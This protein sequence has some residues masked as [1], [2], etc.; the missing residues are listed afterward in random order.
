ME[1][2]AVCAND[3]I[4]D[5]PALAAVRKRIADRFGLVPS[6]FMM[7]QRRGSS[8]CSMASSA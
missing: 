3:P 6:F 4:D 7:R 5:A 2:T 1:S 8:V